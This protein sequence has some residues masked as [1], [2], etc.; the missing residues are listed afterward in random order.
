MGFIH[1]VLL[2]LMEC[3]RRRFECEVQ[4]DKTVFVNDS[5]CFSNFKLLKLKGP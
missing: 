2:I 4:K 5:V 3:V 1:L